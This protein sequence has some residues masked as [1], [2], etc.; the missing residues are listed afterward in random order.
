MSGESISKLLPHFIYVNSRA[1]FAFDAV[2][3]DGKSAGKGLVGGKCVLVVSSERG[4]FGNKRPR[5][6]VVSG[7][8]EVSRRAGLE[9]RRVLRTSRSR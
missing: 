2:H 7:E 3:K 6:A 9:R 8:G 5:V 1:G 4:D